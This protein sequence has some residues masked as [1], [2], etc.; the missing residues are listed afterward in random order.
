MA[1]SESSP[2]PQPIKALVPPLWGQFP[3]RSLN[4]LA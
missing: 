4:R 1:L 3:E 2:T